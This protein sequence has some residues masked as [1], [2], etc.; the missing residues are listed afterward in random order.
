MRKLFRKFRG[1][2]L[3]LP[4]RPS[5]KQIIASAIAVGIVVGL[6]TLLTK[7]LDTLLI[8]GTFGASCLLVFVYPHSPF[9]QPRNVIGAHLLGVTLGLVCLNNLGENW[10]SLTLAV[11]LTVAAMKACGVVHPPATSNPLAVFYIKPAWSFLLFPTLT[12]ALIIIF[13]ALFYH[14]IRSE[15]NWPDYW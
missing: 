2:R 3:K 13:L 8:L 10:W 15:E 9:S 7:H 5:T 11:G 14:N 12:G 4:E 1:S 6:L